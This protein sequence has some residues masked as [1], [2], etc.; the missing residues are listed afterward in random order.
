MIK[1]V[2]LFKLQQMSSAEDLNAKC[3]EIKNSLE[4]LMGK[5]PTLKSIKVSVNC[6]PNEQFHICLEST[7]DDME[8]LQAYATHPLH[9][10]IS[11]E[12]IRPILEARSCVDF[13]F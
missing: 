11:K 10:N 12:L 1:H 7:H 5:I 3:V 2:V 8:G 6:N 13:E 4:D 9:V